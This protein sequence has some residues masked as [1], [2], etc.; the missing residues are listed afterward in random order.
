MSGKIVNFNKKTKKEVKPK[1]EI[2]TF[3]EAVEVDIDRLCSALGIT[4]EEAITTASDFYKKYP[5][6]VE[7]VRDAKTLTKKDGRK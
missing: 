2:T 3:S 5:M 4:R 6:L 7:Y 1:D